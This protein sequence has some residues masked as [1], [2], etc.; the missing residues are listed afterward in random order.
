MKGAAATRIVA[1]G[2]A[3]GWF[4]LRLPSA[5]RSFRS[6]VQLVLS[7]RQISAA[8]GSV[9]LATYDVRATV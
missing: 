1:W 3:I 8:G 9:R 7:A 5:A 2:I 4:T 6:A